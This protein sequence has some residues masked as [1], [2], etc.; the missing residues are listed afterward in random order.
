MR[1]LKTF[2]LT[3]LAAALMALFAVGTASATIIESEG[4]ALPAGTSITAESEGKVR[5][6]AQ[7]G[8][9]ECNK[10]H[11][12]GKSTNAGGAAVNVTFNVESL[13]WSEC[14]ATVTVLNKGTLSIAHSSGSNGTLFGS[15][16][17]VTVVFD[18]F[19]CIFSTKNTNLGTVTGGTNATLHI[20]GTLQRAIGSGSGVFCGQTAPWTGSYKVTT[21]SPFRVTAS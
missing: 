14:N 13:S 7:I 1:Y 17:E 11:L 10:S 5:L 21:P 8:T 2:G 6:D 9:I 3:A 19:H 20:S 16:Q 12:G 15:D 4:G 18:G